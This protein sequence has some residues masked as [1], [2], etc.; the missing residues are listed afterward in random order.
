MAT[1][2][3]YKLHYFDGRGRAEQIRWILVQG[4]AR[5]EDRRIKQ[6][7]WPAIKPNT[8]IGSLPYLE[9]GSEKIATS[10]A[11]AMFLARELGLA[12]VNHLEEA[13][14]QMMWDVTQDVFNQFAKAAYA[15]PETQADLLQA[16]ST[17]AM[18][19]YVTFI[20]K[21][22][23]GGNDWL[24]GNKLSMADLVCASLLD[25]QQGA[26]NQGIRAVKS[27]SA[28]VDRVKQLPNISKWIA[29]RPPSDY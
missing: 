23:E 8:P 27:V 20:A 28:L 18:P 24:V 1:Q 10:A 16:Y 12:A 25:S 6:S 22:L 9:I 3:H 29:N 15:P 21:H 17:V 5:W 13:Q 26:V 7:D 2:K 14:V 19:K 11:V 4:G